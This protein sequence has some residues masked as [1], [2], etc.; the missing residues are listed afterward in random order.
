LIAEA[1]DSV[2]VCPGAEKL[3]ALVVGE[4]QRLLPPSLA[5]DFMRRLAAARG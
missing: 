1:V 5:E 4:I 3:K 2:P